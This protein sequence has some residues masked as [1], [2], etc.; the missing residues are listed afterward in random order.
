MATSRPRRRPLPRRRGAG[1]CP[2]TE[3]PPL[4]SLTAESDFRAFMQPGVDD[5]LRRAALRKMW[6]NPVYGVVDE[7]DP[8]R[9]DFAAFTPL[10]DIVTSDMKFHAERLLR[11]QLEKAAEAPR[12]PASRR[13]GRASGLTRRREPA[14]EARCRRARRGRRR[15][16]DARQNPTFRR[17]TPMSVETPEL[18]STGAA[19]KARA[20]A[21]GSL[22]EMA[23][24]PTSLVTY[25]SH[26]RL[27]VI[28]PEDAALRAARQ[29]AGAVPVTVHVPGAGRPDPG[30]SDGI[31]VVRGGAAEVSGRLGRFVVN[32]STP[33]GPVALAE[34]AGSAAEFF[35]LVLDLGESP[36]IDYE[37]PPV[38]Y[39]APAGRRTRWRGR[40]P[41]FPR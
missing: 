19:G 20:L 33:E 25:Q 13:G 38:G 14:S 12:A 5:A 2:A 16:R 41:R 37:V 30:T 6:Q 31:V 7:L 1:G 32:L 24:T 17:R 3:L 10:G 8:F 34:A 9:A 28:G 29:L 22:G 40:S 27:A 21:L 39:Y 36:L 35:D 18:P 4:E 26:G 23:A 11:E 15:L